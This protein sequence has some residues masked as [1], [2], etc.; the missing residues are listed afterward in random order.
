MD[1]IEEEFI[2]HRKQFNDA[3]D[4]RAN[5]YNKWFYGFC[6]SGEDTLKVKE[7]V[8]NLLEE[9]FKF[10]EYTDYTYKSKVDYV[11]RFFDGMINECPFT[12][13][14]GG[15]YFYRKNN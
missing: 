14:F 13:K 5:K 7:R 9:S 4:E 2:N 8:D 12:D 3:S 11:L 1:A 10:I 6:P 15:I